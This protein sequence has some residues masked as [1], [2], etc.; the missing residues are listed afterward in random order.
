MY[1]TVLVTRS[2][3]VRM[4][5]PVLVQLLLRSHRSLTLCPL[6][7][8]M[9]LT[10]KSTTGSCQHRDLLVEARRVNCNLTLKGH[11]ENLA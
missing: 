2:Y 10:K 3:Q 5:L 8:L 9:T 11:V 1:L 4:P 7:L 6:A